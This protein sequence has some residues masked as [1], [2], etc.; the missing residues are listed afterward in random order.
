MTLKGK[1]KIFYDIIKEPFSN[2]EKDKFEII[3]FKEDNNL[4]FSDKLEITAFQLNSI[5]NKETNNFNTNTFSIYADPF[6]ISK[7]NIN[8]NMN[9]IKNDI[10]IGEMKFIIIG[11]GALFESFQINHYVKYINESIIKFSQNNNQKNNGIYDLNLRNMAKQIL[12]D[13]IKYNKQNSEYNDKERFISIIL[14][15]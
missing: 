1:L 8:N 4:Y 7:E 12:K 13:S 11:N 2:P 3:N 5:K 15:E 6:L 10:N 14:I 9:H